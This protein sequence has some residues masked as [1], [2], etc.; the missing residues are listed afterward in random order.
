MA[1]VEAVDRAVKQVVEATLDVGGFLF[2]TADHGNVEKMWDPA[3]HG[4]HT[5][6]TTTPVPLLLVDPTYNG[7]LA[8]GRLADVV[9]S[10][11]QHAGLEPSSAMTGADL[12][13]R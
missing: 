7:G 5:A 8:D 11:L 6:H 2:I 9:P 10:L 4:P 12:R 13:R 3:T 1:A